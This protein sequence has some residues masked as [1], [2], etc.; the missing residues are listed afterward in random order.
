LTLRA[1]LG[2]AEYEQYL[3]AT[4]SEV[5]VPVNV[6]I[7]STAAQAGLRPGDRIVSYDGSRVFHF[8]ELTALTEGSPSES[9][10]VDVL[11][12][13]QII[14]ISVPRGPLGISRWSD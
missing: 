12:N 4:G 11:R 7:N 1:K 10:I 3:S 8:G 6:P 2:D 14:Q 5:D 9:V 13:G